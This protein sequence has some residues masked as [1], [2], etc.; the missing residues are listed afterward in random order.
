M[1]KAKS[2]SQ[3]KKKAA[4]GSNARKTAVTRAPAA[5]STAPAARKK[6]MALG[7]NAKF[8][9]PA[10]RADSKQSKVIGLLQGVDGT[11]IEAIMKETG[12]QQHSV[13]GFFAG[14][15]RKRL[16]LDLD[17]ELVDGTRRYWVKKALQAIG[18]KKLAKAI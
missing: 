13:R 5:K 6:T 2:Q 15:V 17:S 18:E 3:A 7:L 11:T 1:T 16:K 8:K 9:V 12:W 14:V 10:S 4:A